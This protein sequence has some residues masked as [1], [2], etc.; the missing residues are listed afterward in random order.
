MRLF[1]ETNSP[2]PCAI[3]PFQYTSS[4]F[5]RTNSLTKETI[6]PNTETC[7]MTRDA[8]TRAVCVNSIFLFTNSTFL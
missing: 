5:Q 7:S 4:A 1:Q 2:V 8:I 6:S 3:S